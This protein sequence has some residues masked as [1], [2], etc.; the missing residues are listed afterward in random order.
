MLHTSLSQN[1]FLVI[2]FSVLHW[3][4]VAKLDNSNCW[5]LINFQHC[6]NVYQPNKWSWEHK[7]W[8]NF[9]Q[10]S[11][12]FW[13]KIHSHHLRI[14]RNRTFL[15]WKNEKTKTKPQTAHFHTPHKFSVKKVTNI[16][17]NSW[18]VQSQSLCQE[19]ICVVFVWKQMTQGIQ[20]WKGNLIWKSAESDLKFYNGKCIKDQ[21]R[22]STNTQYQEM[23]KWSHCH[24]TK[25]SQTKVKL[26]DLV[27]YNQYHKHINKSMELTYQQ[28]C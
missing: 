1:V 5:N 17:R 10:L 27:K 6:H 4:K 9:Q 26:Q 18:T 22:S 3:C 20:K 14:T 19:D 21:N 23:A 24:N 11:P 28:V 15:K 8:S 25:Q 12:H 7:I 13:Y 2:V 16:Y